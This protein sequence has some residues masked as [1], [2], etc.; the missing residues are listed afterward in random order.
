MSLEVGMLS[1]PI[2]LA[3]AEIQ[4][5][6]GATE[7]NI[8][9]SVP[10]GRAPR[11]RSELLCSRPQPLLHLFHLPL[12][13]GAAL[14]AGG[15]TRL[16]DAQHGSVHHAICESLPTLDLNPLPARLRDQPSDW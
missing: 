13:P 11:L 14:L 12:S 8:G 6:E 15:T 3:Q 10:I 4:I 16:K 5:S 9:Q 7:R 1:A 2:D